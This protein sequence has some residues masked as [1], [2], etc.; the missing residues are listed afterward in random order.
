MLLPSAARCGVTAVGIFVM[1]AGSWKVW[2][3][4]KGGPELQ[5]FAGE[6]RQLARWSYDTATER[7]GPPAAAVQR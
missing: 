1:T 2:P 6:H 5:M 4:R 3:P 7:S